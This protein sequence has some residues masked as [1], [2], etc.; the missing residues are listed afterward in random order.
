M[1]IRQR[2]LPLGSTQILKKL[3]KEK[4][5]EEAVSVIGQSDKLNNDKANQCLAVVTEIT[6]KAFLADEK[7]KEEVFGP[8]S[9]LIAA[10]NIAQ[11]QQV[12]NS[13]PT[14]SANSNRDGRK[15]RRVVAI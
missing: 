12:L 4:L 7:Y 10:D 1:L 3:S 15:R 9:M 8:Y 5:A 14:W 13:L 2:C 6:A 11:L